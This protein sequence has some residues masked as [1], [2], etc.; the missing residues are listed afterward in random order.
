MEHNFQIT[1]MRSGKVFAARP[2]EKILDAAL[3]QEVWLPSAC[4]AGTCGCCSATVVEGHVDHCDAYPAVRLGSEA[5]LCCAVALTDLILDVEEHPARPI[6]TARRLPARVIEITRASD[7]VAVI[8]LRLPSSEPLR[9][10]PG[11]Y[12]TIIPKDRRPRPFSIANGPR[13]DGTI[14]LHIGKIP[15]GQFTDY[16]HSEL[17][18]G[19]VLRL[20][21]PLGSF[22]LQEESN[23]PAVFIAG[24]TGIAPIKAILETAVQAAQVSRKIHVY[25]GSRR[26]EGLYDRQWISKL[27]SCDGTIRFTPVV[28]EPISSELWTGRRGLVHRAVMEDLPDLSEFEAYVCGSP[29][30]IEAAFRDLTCS[31]GLAPFRFYSDA[32]YQ[33]QPVTG[34]APTI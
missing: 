10:R 8:T 3:R 2:G 31:A 26:P 13:R 33:P 19:E 22:G 24:G 11:Q 14:E 27:A 6:Q 30:L 7:E 34:R 5:R 32:F 23:R 15:G 16:V 1:I 12:V 21:G 9:Y 17:Q 29:A 20:E 18:P 25:W 4:R 28:S